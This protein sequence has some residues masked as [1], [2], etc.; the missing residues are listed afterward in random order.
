MVD[1]QVQNASSPK[2]P[3]GYHHAGR[4]ATTAYT[5]LMSLD[6]DETLLLTCEHLTLAATH[7][8]LH[9]LPQMG[10]TDVPNG[11]LNGSGSLK[12]T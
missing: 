9:L 10:D 4:D 5:G 8:N 7:I 11:S 3:V 1:A 2:Y 12:A 6:D